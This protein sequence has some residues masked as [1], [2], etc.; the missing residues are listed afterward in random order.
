MMDEKPLA[1]VSRKENPEYVN[2]FQKLV[3]ETNPRL[4]VRDLRILCSQEPIKFIDE[5][6]RMTVVG[7]REETCQEKTIV[8]RSFPEMMG[9]GPIMRLERFNALKIEK[10]SDN[11][12]LW[13]VNGNV[14]DDHVL[15]IGSK[16]DE[17]TVFP[18]KSPQNQQFFL[19]NVDYFFVKEIEIGEKIKKIMF[20]YNLDVKTDYFNNFKTEDETG[21]NF[22]EATYD[23]LRPEDQKMFEGI[24]D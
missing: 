1:K 10:F 17:L 3:S 19:T 2:H 7:E 9:Y 11:Y 13:L 23:L 21:K 16:D 12:E 24:L 15:F 8:G 5:E 22:L 20:K 6:K 14:I 4:T 18:K